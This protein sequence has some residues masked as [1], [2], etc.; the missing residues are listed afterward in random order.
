MLAAALRRRARS[1]IAAAWGVQAAIASAF[2]GDG[3]ALEAFA[4]SISPEED[5]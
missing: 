1:A 2:A 4:E 5:Q 3:K